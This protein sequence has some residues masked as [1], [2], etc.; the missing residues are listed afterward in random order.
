MAENLISK[1][2]KEK[3]TNTAAIF[4]DKKI[5]FEPNLEEIEDSF[6]GCFEYDLIGSYHTVLFIYY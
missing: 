2:E 3:S 6:F 1:L 4:N 5:K